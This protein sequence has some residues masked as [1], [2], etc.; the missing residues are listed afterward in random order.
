MEMKYFSMLYFINMYL[1][2]KIPE[3]FGNMKF[4]TIPLPHKP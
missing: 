3:R 2:L 1:L 4:N